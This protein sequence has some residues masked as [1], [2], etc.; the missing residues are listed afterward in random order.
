M[1][2]TTE[3]KIMK[4]TKPMMITALVAG[5][6]LVWSLALYAQ[7]ATNAPPAAPPAGGPPPG[8][9]PGSGMRGR[10]DHDRLI[11]QLNLTDDQKPKVNAILDDQRD[12]M[13]NVFQDQ[14]LSREDRM[15]KI[16]S[17]RENTDAK[18][19]VILTADQFEKWQ[20][21]EPRMRGP[22]NGPPPGAPPPGGGGTNTPPAK[23]PQT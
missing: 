9:P 7:G 5:S 17:I 12:K 13:H 22:R 14:N 15:A 2:T 8:G 20:K 19:K 1:K 6:L 11:E 3:A 4:C 16:K 23:P 10:P 21:M 18:L